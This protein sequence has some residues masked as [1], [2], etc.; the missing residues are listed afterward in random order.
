MIQVPEGMSTFHRMH[1]CTV[2][3]IAFVLLGGQQLYPFVASVKLSVIYVV[4]VQTI[5]IKRVYGLNG[6]HRGGFAFL[7]RPE[8][9][10]D[11]GNNA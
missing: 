5:M 11:V 3:L 7:V 6:C 1:I 4:D 9:L 10:L 8:F 2:V